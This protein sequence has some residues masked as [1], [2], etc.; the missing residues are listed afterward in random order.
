MNDTKKRCDF[1]TSMTFSVYPHEK[2][3]IIRLMQRNSLKSSFD[4][5]RKMAEELGL[6]GLELPKVRKNS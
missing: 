5:V 4:V 6:P 2:E 3:T 1:A